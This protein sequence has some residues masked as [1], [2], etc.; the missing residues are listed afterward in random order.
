MALPLARGR[1]L[2]D[3]DYAAHGLWL[4]SGCGPNRAE[5]VSWGELLSAELLYDLAAWNRKGESLDR[6]LVRGVGLPTHFFAEARRL[7]E[8]V[9]HELG[10]SWEVLYVGRAGAWHWVK[11]PAA[12]GEGARRPG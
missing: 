2:V 5:G 8:R 3:W 10:Q 6:S 12:W 1:A 11:P 4:V 7:A 9:Q